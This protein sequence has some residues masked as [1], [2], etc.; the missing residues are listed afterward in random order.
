[1]F[2]C[3]SVWLRW[4]TELKTRREAPPGPTGPIGNAGPTLPVTPPTRPALSRSGSA[5]GQV[6]W[7]N[8]AQN[9]SNP[10]GERA[11][12]ALTEVSWCGRR[13]R[14][15]RRSRAALHLALPPHPTAALHPPAPA[16]PG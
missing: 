7:A 13:R 14:H 1:V 8:A 12:A 16:V 3:S 5:R 4:I 2:S 10:V 6:S 9:D 15:T 11:S